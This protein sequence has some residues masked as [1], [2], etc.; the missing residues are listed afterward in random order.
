MRAL[1]WMVFSIA[2]VAQASSTCADTLDRLQPDKLQAVHEA[3]EG[4]KPQR[5]AVS[6]SSGYQDVRTLLHVHSS[7]SHDSRGKIE[8][9]IAAAKEAHIRVIMFSEHPASSYDYFIDGHRGLKD[10]VLLIPGAETG[11]FLAYPRQSVQNQ[12]TDTPQAFADLVRTTEGQIF[13][14]HLEERMDWNIANVTGTEIYNTHAD[15]KDETRFLAA[16]RSP[17]TMFSL[18]GAVKQ[19]PQEVFGALLDYP[20]DYLQALR[21]IVPGGPAHG[22]CR[23]RLTS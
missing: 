2:W 12:K 20:A 4:L 16:L 23:Q 8:E 9:I 1:L 22:R 14:C 6:L 15:F 10:G 7:F 18:M 19:Y 3:I 21:P 5:R 11:G 17:L 13:V